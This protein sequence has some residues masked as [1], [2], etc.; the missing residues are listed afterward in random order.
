M[1]QFKNSYL[2][3]PL[4]ARMIDSVAAQ[5]RLNCCQIILWRIL[6][7]KFNCNGENCKVNIAGVVFSLMFFA[8]GVCPLV[9]STCCRYFR[10]TI[11]L[12]DGII[13]L[14]H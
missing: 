5:E 2:T 6:H 4:L 14:N 12:Y 11:V 13:F 8:L 9:D 7:V 1:H 3:T 10:L